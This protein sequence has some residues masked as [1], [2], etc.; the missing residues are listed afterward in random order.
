MTC[1]DALIAR[2][3]LALIDPPRPSQRPPAV[4]HRAYPASPTLVGLSAAF[5]LRRYRRFD[6]R[7]DS[8]SLVLI[9]A[10]GRLPYCFLGRP[11][12]CRARAH[13]PPE[14]VDARRRSSLRIRCLSSLT[15]LDPQPCASSMTRAIRRRG[16]R[17]PTSSPRLVALTGE[18]DARTAHGGHDGD[19]GGRLGGERDPVAGGRA[20]ARAAGCAEFGPR[21]RRPRRDD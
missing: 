17:R 5:W 15:R 10:S 16:P 2:S 8:D 4:S 18:S 11:R 3:L 14:T 7:P 13:C 19:R 9:R 1:V 20:R 21:P 12:C 6:P